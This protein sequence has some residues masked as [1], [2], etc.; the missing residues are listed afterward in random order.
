VISF[1]KLIKYAQLYSEAAN[2]PRADYMRQYM[3]NRYH[4]TR[5]KVIDRLGGKCVR[6]GTTEGTLHLDH[7]DAKKKTMRASDLHSV[8]DKRF[9]AEIKNLQVL[10]EDCHRD[11][12]FEDWDYSSLTPKKTHGSYWFYRKYRCR[13]PECTKA[14][15]D[16]QKE[17]RKQQKDNRIKELNKMNKSKT[18]D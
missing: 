2:H 6:C 7:K 12:T 11:K 9:E 1:D 4:Q 15:Q 14:Y 13:C 5:K 8:N 10:C 16:K 18:Q 3:A 17:W